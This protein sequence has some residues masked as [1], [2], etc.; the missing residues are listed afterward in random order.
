LQ[1]DG[2]GCTLQP[3]G[4]IVPG[5]AACGRVFCGWQR[6]SV[7]SRKS[8]K[9]V[10]E[11]VVLFD[12]DYNVLDGIVRLQAETSIERSLHLDESVCWLMEA[13]AEESDR[14]NLH[15]NIKEH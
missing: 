9:V 7:C 1:L 10:V 12:D 3:S 13:V 14:E 8:T 15:A 6:C 11:G 5:V 2:V 4:V